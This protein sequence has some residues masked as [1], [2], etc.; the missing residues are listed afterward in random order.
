MQNQCASLL[1]EK[2]QHLSDHL[3]S[4]QTIS[5]RKNKDIVLSLNRYFDCERRSAS[6]SD[7]VSASG[8]FPAFSPEIASQ[9]RRFHASIPNY[10]PTPLLK[11]E[12]LA[13][14]I[15]V[16]K[17]WIKDES[18]RFGLN[19]FK[20]LGSSYA[21]G[22]KANQ[23]SAEKK[24]ANGGD[25]KL[26]CVGE[27]SWQQMIEEMQGA[28]LITATDGNHGYG[29]AWIASQLP[30]PCHVLMPRGSAAARVDRTRK[31]G[32]HVRVTT[33]GYDATV[34][35]AV[36]IAAAN[37][38]LLVQDTS[39][40]GY[41]EIPLDIMQGYTTIFHEALGEIMEKEE[42]PTH[43]FLQAGVGSF[44]GGLLAYL[45]NFEAMMDA[46]PA[47]VVIVEA[48]GAECLFQSSDRSDGKPQIMTTP[49]DTIMAG[50][51]CSSPCTIAW[52]ILRKA[53][54]AFLRCSDDIAACGMKLAFRPFGD[55][56]R[57]TSGES[58]A[59]TLGAVYKICIADCYVDIKEKLNLNERSRILLVSTEGDTD[60]EGFQKIVN[61]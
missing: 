57:I 18:K 4:T 46:S 7:S 32:A 10:E 44:A 21:I 42:M 22:K 30:S 16:E 34:D 60:P 36:D 55:D 28:P 33:V 58:G 37:D 49:C 51:N 3:V 25:P 15:G 56:P 1:E 31:L 19:A 13:A 2:P 14:E 52:P 24:K 5:V 20:V 11:L 53:S 38:W 41:E 61:P 8:P 6:P 54:N 48:E 45:R 9:V 43:V 59:V 50:L 27:C 29:V 47:I 39:F 35:E 40:D 23:K 17:V 12:Q 26:N